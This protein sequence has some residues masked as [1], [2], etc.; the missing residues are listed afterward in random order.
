MVARLTLL[1]ENENT[2]APL[3]GLASGPA[4]PPPE[5]PPELPPELPPEPPPLEPPELLP[6]ELLLDPPLLEPLEL[7]DPE[8]LPDPPLDEPASAPVEVSAPASAVPPE[9]PEL[10]AASKTSAAVKNLVCVRISRRIVG[11]SVREGPGRPASS[12]M[13]TGR[14]GAT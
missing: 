6:P 1:G 3:S 10:Q 4:S 9:L 7:P 11:G 14:K 13:A 12:I 8:L 5:P 2:G